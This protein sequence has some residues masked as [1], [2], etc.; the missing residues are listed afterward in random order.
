VRAA[1][2]NLQSVAPLIADRCGL[3]SLEPGTFN[4]GL[5]E[6]YPLT[7]VTAIIGPG[8]Y[9]HQQEVIKLRRCRIRRFGSSGPGVRGVVIR[10]SQHE[11]PTRGGGAYWT[12]LEI[13]SPH[14]LRDVL[15]V[16]TGDR[17]A[18][19]L[20]GENHRDDGWWNQPEEIG[21]I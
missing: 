12:R 21:R 16:N 10:P 14:R 3:P 6:H 11:D 1:S 19:E 13:M 18:V 4:V 5:V 7:A 17:V 15:R 20:E 9:G 8:E 2:R